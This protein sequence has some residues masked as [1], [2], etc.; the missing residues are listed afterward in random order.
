MNWKPGWQVSSSNITSEIFLM[1]DKRDN[2]DSNSDNDIKHDPNDPW[3]SEKSIDNGTNQAMIKNLEEKST[4]TVSDSSDTGNS[5]FER[6]VLNR[7]A[8]AAVNE[9]RR[10]RRW[11]IF[12]KFAMLSYVLGILYL[13]IPKDSTDMTG[14]AHTALVEISGPIADNAFAN[15]NTVITGLRNAYK[16]KNSKGIIIRINSPGGS[17][18]QAGYINDEIYRLKEKHPKIPV[19][20]VVTDICA[21]AA[22][23]IAVAADEI[24]ADKASIVGSIGV[25]MDGYG[26]VDT[27]KKLGIERRLMT[28]GSNKAFLDPFSPVKPEDQAHMQG[29]L[30]NI[31]DQ[32]I[33]VV[34]K[35]RGDRLLD[36]PKMFSGLVWSGEKSV[37]LGI[38][39][40]LGSVG[41]VAREVI[42]AKKIVDYTPRAN[43]LDRFAEKIGASTATAFQ[44]MFG[45][46]T[47]K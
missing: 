29:L 15:A 6:D 1:T 2:V 24:Y 40:G 38:I 14:G 30:N 43:Y 33:A 21:S 34:K 47:I 27:I 10:S 12:F 46:I 3:T 8:F 5:S 13:Y 9:Q 19:Y 7:L 25:L 44:S 26:F 16:N 20:V 28:A 11:G 18:V 39:D 45:Q 31:H 32:F 4:S 22:Y 17:P 41:Y 36:H 37:D 23:Y 42:G 35:G